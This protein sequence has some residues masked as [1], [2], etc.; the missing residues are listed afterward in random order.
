[1]LASD[2]TSDSFRKMR[3]HHSAL[4][5]TIS[6]ALVS[7]TSSGAWAATAAGAAS[8]SNKTLQPEDEDYSPS[9]YTAYGEFNQDEDEAE[10]MRFYQ[11]GR[12]FGVGVLLGASGAT[13]NRGKLWQGGVPS[14]KVMTQ[15]W[16]NFNLALQLELMTFKHN[17]ETSTDTFTANILALGM[18]FKYYI[19]TKNL[20][21]TL[22]FANPHF[23]IGFADYAKTELASKSA[24]TD[25]ADHAL[26]LNA[27]LG[28][29]FPLVNRKTYV[30]FETRAHFV[31]FKDSESPKYQAPADGGFDNLQGFFY[32]FHLGL[33]A[34][35]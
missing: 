12:L 33:V 6:F 18:N 35:W 29:E 13:G 26:G 21:A 15:Y 9:P 20:S 14:V 1:M 25:P 24:T 3:S 8:P 34:T 7:L 5:L 23:I 10:E 11:H 32:T 2:S 19:D 22:T 4:T 31:S 17:Y 30:A 27:G 16:F 28:F